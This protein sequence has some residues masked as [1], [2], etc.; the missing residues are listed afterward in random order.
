MKIKRII[1]I[2]RKIYAGMMVWEGDK[3]TQIGRQLSIQS[4]A[5]S[6]VSSIEMSVHAG[7]HVDAPFH[8]FET[9]LDISCLDLSQ[10]IGF[11]KVFTL[12]VSDTIQ[13]K[14]L[15]DLDIQ[16]GDIVIL[17]TPNSNLPEEEPVSNKFIPLDVSAAKYFVEKKVK[18]VGVDHLSIDAFDSSAFAVHKLLL[19][20][21]IGIIE[22]LR[23]KEV[24][25]GEYLLSALPLR[26]EGVD[27]SPI[28]AVLIELG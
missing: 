20:N 3:P 5:P 7:S 14:D 15:E 21:H 11:A 12:D 18:T 2:S 23:L 10:F 25:T 28:R 22:G 4:G 16:E 19:S 17:K 27:G 1:D 9:G 13:K 8:F 26:I 24:S 6:N